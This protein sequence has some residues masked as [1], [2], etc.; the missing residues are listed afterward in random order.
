MLII[1]FEVKFLRG[2]KKAKS[3]EGFRHFGGGVFGGGRL[4]GC[5]GSWNGGH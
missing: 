2:K 1:H 3:G 4:G 5:L